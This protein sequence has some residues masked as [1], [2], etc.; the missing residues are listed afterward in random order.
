MRAP[1]AC[2]NAH[3]TRV[4]L[5]CPGEPGRARLLARAGR[6]M[7]VRK[8]RP[9]T[10]PAPLTAVT[11]TRAP[12]THHR[13][14]AL[15]QLAGEPA[16]PSG[17]V[18]RT[19]KSPPYKTSLFSIRKNTT[20]RKASMR[21]VRWLFFAL[22]STGI[23]GEEALPGKSGLCNP[24]AAQ[25]TTSP[26]ESRAPGIFQVGFPITFVEVTD[27]SQSVCYMYHVAHCHQGFLSCCNALLRALG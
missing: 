26:T 10:R 7:N 2:G 6:A 8:G 27:N 13:G 1:V 17:K 5:R 11:G 20:H 3:Q 4:P 21:L 25:Q 16:S 23:R 19:L 15:R 18:T 9:C 24:S 14:A 22:E 12:R